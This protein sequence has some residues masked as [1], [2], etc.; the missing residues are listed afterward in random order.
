MTLR[1]GACVVSAASLLLVGACGNAKSPQP[2]NVAN[3]QAAQ[4]LP[5]PVITRQVPAESRQPPDSVPS[6]IYADTNLVDGRGVIAGKV[7]KNI[8]IVA[9]D[10]SM[11]N[12]ARQAVLSRVHGSIVGGVRMQPE[13]GGG[14]YYVRVDAPTPSAVLA[15]Q[16][17]L[18]PIPGVALVIPAMNDVIGPDM[19][20]R[21]LRPDTISRAPA[22]A[23]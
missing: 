7:A 6:W 2:P 3:N 12:A 21:G 4:S 11:T 17:T 16:D 13:L 8:L 20:S 15:L 9:F 23:R 14:F 1:G 10:S 18:T 19:R 5:A 22:S